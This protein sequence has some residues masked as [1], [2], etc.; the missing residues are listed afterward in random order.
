MKGYKF[1]FGWIETRSSTT[2]EKEPEYIVRGYAT[3]PNKPYSYHYK[4]DKQ[5]KPINSLKEIIST[6]GVK[7]IGKK[8]MSKKIFVDSEHE[9]GNIINTKQILNKIGEKTGADITNETNQIIDNIKHSDIPLAKITDFE[10]Q[11]DGLFVEAKLNPHYR[12]VNEDHEKYFDAIWGSLQSK[13]LNG[14]S[15]NQNTE[16][17]SFLNSAINVL[18]NA[19]IIMPSLSWY[20]N[21]MLLLRLTLLLS[22][23]SLKPLNSWSLTLWSNSKS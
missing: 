4:V 7:N 10:V 9:I 11:D 22:L 17:T 3:V 20:S 15:I 21:S 23:K 14:I 2:Q 13:F 12:N 19:L 18:L 5:G 16:K 6:E 1:Q 8:L